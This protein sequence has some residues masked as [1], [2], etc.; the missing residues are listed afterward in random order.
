[1]DKGSQIKAMKKIQAGIVRKDMLSRRQLLEEEMKEIEEQRKARIYRLEEMERQVRNYKETR[2][3]S[4]GRLTNYTSQGVY[5]EQLKG[6]HN[7]AKDMLTIDPF[8]SPVPEDKLL[9]KENLKKVIKKAAPVKIPVMVPQSILE[10]SKKLQ[11]PCI[12]KLMKN[13]DVCSVYLISDSSPVYNPLV[14]AEITLS[15]DELER[16][17]ES[18][19]GELVCNDIKRWRSVSPKKKRIEDLDLTKPESMNIREKTPQVRIHRHMYRDYSSGDSSNNSTRQ[20]VG[21]RMKMYSDIVKSTAKPIVSEKKQ[22]E[23]QMIKDKLNKHKLGSPGRI[24]LIL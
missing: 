6:L 22:I 2:D 12:Q 10:R 18:F 21:K 4:M 20:W 3:A 16:K 14:K 24:K 17:K 8:L 5:L 13:G 1:M 15:R 19:H 11:P 7:K 9:S 23:I